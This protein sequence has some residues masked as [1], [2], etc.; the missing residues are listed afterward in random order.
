MTQSPLDRR[1]LLALSVSGGAAVIAAGCAQGET[2]A[3]GARPTLTKQTTEGPYYF[4]PQVERADVTEGRK[5]VPL[6]VRFIVVD[7][8]GSPFPA[9]RV[10]IWHCDAGGLYSGY[11]GQGED[12]KTTTEGEKFLRGWV[13]TDANGVASFTTIYPGWYRGRTTHILFKVWSADTCVLTA[14]FFLPDALSEFL[15]T[16]LG[17]Y[18][19]TQLRDTL[20]STDGIAIEA[21]ETVIGNV[22]EEADRYVASLNVAVDRDAKPTIDR[23]GAP[24]AR[25]PGP[26]PG[27]PPGRDPQG[28]PPNIH[29]TLTGETRTAALVPKKKS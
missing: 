22:R 29:S 6:E 23:P 11:A 19:R 2:P 24:G 21:G 26:P 14:Q 3:L 12:G 20:N 25:P 4:D 5:G 10:D 16:Q 18:K 28:G 27:G 17:D 13:K 15:Y 8:T 9:T 1:R 7:E